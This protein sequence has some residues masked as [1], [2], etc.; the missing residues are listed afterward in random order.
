MIQDNDFKM[1]L[2]TLLGEAFGALETDSGFF[3][4]NGQ[5]GLLGVLSEVDAATASA[6]SH[7]KNATIASHAA[8][9]LYVIDL[10]LAHEQ[11]EHPRADW[12]A[13][14]RERAVTDSA[15]AKLRSDLHARYAEVMRRLDRRTD[16][17]GQA[18]GAWMMLLAHVSYHVGEIR[19]MR[20]A[21]A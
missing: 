3:M 10:F 8:H 18:A 5:N 20:T 17:S 11:G 14:W 1:P 7:P 4:D 16:W 21:L 6:A 2:A 13:A 12:E 15:W 9:V 19:Q